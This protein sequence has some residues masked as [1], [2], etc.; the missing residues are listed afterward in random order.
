MQALPLKKLLLA[1]LLVGT[2]DITAACVDS[3]LSHHIAPARVLNGIAGGVIGKENANGETADIVL[4]LLV[5]YFIA[6]SFTFLF[7]FVYPPLK[8]LLRYN[9]LIGF[10]YGI[11][12]WAAMRF[13]V[14]PN[15]SKLNLPP[16][17]IRKAIKPALIL[18]G[19]IGI[20]LSLLA[21]WLYRH[22]NQDP[23]Y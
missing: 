17:D 11:F 4:G 19:A 6:Y 8:K 15:L 7:W 13:L 3:W 21:G 20:P 23:A 5:H 2:L 22:E 12:I 18:A 14:L 1:G 9:L 10:L 16:F